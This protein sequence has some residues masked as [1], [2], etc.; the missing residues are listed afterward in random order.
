LKVAVFNLTVQLDLRHECV[1]QKHCPTSGASVA[2]QPI[3][4]RIEI[5]IRLPS[6]AKPARITVH[7]HQTLERGQ[8]VDVM[9]F[10]KGTI[11]G[12]KCSLAAGVI[13][14]FG[15][16]GLLGWTAS[17][18]APAPA[19][20]TLTCD[21]N[22]PLDTNQT[23][24]PPTPTPIDA[25]LLT[26][27]LPCAE[28]VNPRGVFGDDRLAN[29]Q[30]G[31]DFYSWL[32]FLALNSPADGRGIEK[33]A[34]NTKTK[35]ED[36]NNFRQ[37]LD[38]ML[39]DGRAPKWEEK[40]IPP[41]CRSQHK[42]GM[43]VIEMIEETF[44]QPFKTGPLI[45]QRG[46]FALFD[47]LMNKQTF[48]YIVQHGLYS[49]TVQM[50]EDRSKLK[51]DFPPGENAK[52]DPGSII[53]KVSWKILDPKDDKGKFHTVDALVSMPR[54][55][56]QT[57]PPCLRKTLGLVGFHAMHK[58]KSRPQWI[59]TSFEHVDNVPEQKDIEARNLK[60]SYN[61]FDPSCDTAKCKV[62]ETPPRPWEPKHA[63]G[64]KFH[65]KEFKSQITR[66]IPLTD[67][68]KKMNKQF[69]DILGKTVWKNYM[70]LSTQWPSDFPCTQRFSDQTN[71]EPRTEFRKEPDMTC[72][73]APTYLANSTLETYSQG[74]EPLAS[75]SCMACH[76]NA[77]S[78]QRRPPNLKPEDF[79]N[80]SDF[81]FMLEKAREKAR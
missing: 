62:N 44:N 66:V 40:A 45:D 61:F 18:Q 33:S 74:S 1:G 77:V 54:H 39:P 65:D 28:N 10:R 71:P 79:F 36:M 80:Q 3:L 81:T 78:H 67:E 63:L 76:G 32:T 26:K 22:P 5:L 7:Q 46:N 30:R 15:V 51:I 52:G 23:T 60:Q 50:S 16:V 4:T 20:S 11:M 72:A 29:L 21:N 14:V 70:L 27:G 12:T 43:M 42:P 35:W 58:T 64:L 6:P 69:Q 59:W 31:F 57:E 17:A 49:K 68:T 53:L 48:D 13:G 55:D 73:P 56:P 37:L 2:A 47:I 75:S 25:S 9:E 34:P 24:D 41:G 38:V 19:A 8:R